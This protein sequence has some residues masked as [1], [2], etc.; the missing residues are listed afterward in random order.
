MFLRGE[1]PPR[2]HKSRL[3]FYSTAKPHPTQ[4]FGDFSS[5]VESDDALIGSL[6]VKETLY[7]AAQLSLSGSL[8]AVERIR[9]INELLQA[10]GLTNQANTL[11]GILLKKGISMVKSVDWV[12]RPN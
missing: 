5:Y 8:A 6:T 11:I 12:S 4:P 1:R 2:K 9:R 10:F 7:F 3:S